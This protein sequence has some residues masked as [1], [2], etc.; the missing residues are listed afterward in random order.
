MVQTTSL[1]TSFSSFL[2]E[3]RCQ[4]MTQQPTG[5]SE[6]PFAPLPGTA[7]VGLAGSGIG[8]SLSPELHAAEAAAQGAPLVFALLDAQAL[9]V[10]FPRILD[11]AAAAG[12][13]G[14]SVTQPFK[15]EAFEAAD[16]L[17]E[18]ARAVGSVNLLARRPE[19]WT[20]YNTDGVGFGAELD[21]GL[22]AATDYR[23]VVQFGA[24]GVGVSTAR[25]VLDRG[26]SRLTIID[27]DPGRAGAL[28]QR[29]AE[30]YPDREIASGGLGLA[31]RAVPPAS[32]VV[33]ASVKGSAAHPG[34]PVEPAL[35]GGAPW[36][37]DVIYD[38]AETELLRIAREAGCRTVGGG[39]M[40][41]HQAA[42][43]FS[44]LLGRPADSDRMWRRF[45]S[46]RT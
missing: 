6:D 28:A 8:Y 27:L 43:A 37:A 2:H 26:A 3:R 20:G 7:R 45:L 30:L 33:N 42:A 41:V 38:P 22:G 10:P 1:S 5:S 14:L 36:V 40:L 11:L 19:G 46:L 39:L 31:A 29:L 12:Y 4:P 44:I 25:V 34:S 23:S 16:S 15:I 18:S 9:G 32:G 13:V 35:L 21:L 17:D 24:G